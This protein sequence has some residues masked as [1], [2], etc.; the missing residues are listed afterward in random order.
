M[1]K[2]APCDLAQI[3]RH[4]EGKS[5]AVPERGQAKGCEECHQTAKMTDPRRKQALLLCLFVGRN[6]HGGL[7]P[8]PRPSS[9]D[10]EENFRENETKSD[11]TTDRG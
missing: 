5:K 11:N 9:H 6:G 2:T 7:I 10:T 1:G 4:S 3:P 8:I